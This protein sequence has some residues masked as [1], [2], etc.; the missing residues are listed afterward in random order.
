MNEYPGL[1][2]SENGNCLLAHFIPPP[3]RPLLDCDALRTLLDQAGYGKWAFP[4]ASLAKLVESYNAAT[5]EFELPIGER[6]DASFSLELSPDAMQ[7]WARIIPACGGAFLEPE[8]I[9]LALG[10]AGVTH[11]IDQAVVSAACAANVEDHRVLVASGT[12]AENGEDSRFELLVAD[13][14][15]RAPQVAEN[16]LV[17]FRELGAIPTVVAEQALMR[18][19][20]PTTGTAGRNVRG[21]VI[22]PVAGKNALFAEKLVGAY[23]DRDDANLLRAEFSGQPVCCGNAVNI[24]HVLHVRNVNLASGNI[25][26]D[27][28]V[29]VEGDVL[30]GMKVH[31]TGDIVVGGVVDG[32]ELDAGGDIRIGGGIIAKALVRA[33]GAVAAR[34]VENAQ[35]LAGTTIA[36][37][38]SAL[39][40][41]L[42]ANNQILVGI[43]SPQRGRLAGG[44]ARAMMLIRAPIFGSSTGGVTRLLLGVNPVLEAQYQELCH[45]IDKQREEEN[46]LEK[47]VKHLSKPGDKAGGGMLERAKNSWQQ[48]LQAWAKLMPQKEELERQL[49]LISGARIEVG[50]SVEGA[51]DLAF[52]K[53]VMRLR[54]SYGAGSLSMAGDQVVFTDGAGNEIPAS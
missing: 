42:Q 39:Q 15:D 28:T 21:E 37:D 49:A 43:K 38:D 3:A 46:N 50:G 20:P 45:R 41:E 30:S 32:A 10:E 52:G 19:V 47:L 8:T 14:R 2:F 11:G 44:S 12:P 9:Y 29:H 16:G 54:R 1:E 48:A 7:A 40:A 13:A 23:V 25:V 51:I 5:V 53:K 18:R 35:V 22:E 17:D 26:F 36:I 34:F 33:G 6:R 31:A 4:D 24:E 27:G